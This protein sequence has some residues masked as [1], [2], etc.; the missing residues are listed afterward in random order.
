MYNKVIQLYIIYDTCKNICL[1]FF[2]FFSVIYRF[3][4]CDSEVK[5]HLQHRRC[6]FNPWVVKIP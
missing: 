4:P 5:I 2:R 6:R 3:F 1:S